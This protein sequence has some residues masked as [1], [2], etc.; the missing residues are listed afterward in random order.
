MNE[1][2]ML[3]YKSLENAILL[4]YLK[5]VIA[6]LCFPE[7]NM[8][9]KDSKGKMKKISPGIPIVGTSLQLLIQNVSVVG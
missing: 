3:L 6:F 5:I 4:L 9:S 8:F 2:Q 1:S 7:I